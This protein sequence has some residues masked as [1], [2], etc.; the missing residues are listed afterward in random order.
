MNTKFI[1]VS[2]GVISGLG[3]G[4]CAASLGLLLQSRGYTVNPLKCENY[5]NQDSGTINPIDH[6]DPFLCEDGLEADMDLGVYERLLDKNMGKNNFVTKG[7][8]FKRILE[9]ERSMSYNGET[10]EDIPHVL[11]EIVERIKE[12]GRGYDFCII[13]IGGTAGEYQNVLYYEASR[14]M[15]TKNPKDVLNVHVSYMP[16]PKHLGEPK[17]KPT[18]MTVRILMSM[19]I[20]PDFLILRSEA[21]LDT[22]RRKL[23]GVKTSIKGEDII[24]AKDLDNIYRLPLEF[25]N[26]DFD[27]KVLKEF[28][29]PKKKQ[30]LN[31]WKKL[32]ESIEKPRKRKIAV[33]IA[34]KY[35][36]K[37]E[38]D[39]EL[40]DAYHALI[41]ALKHASWETNIDIDLHLVNVTKK[42]FEKK[43]KDLD[44][45]IVP[46]GWGKRGVEGKIKSITFARENKVPY[47]GLCY[48]MQLA[49]V[50]YARN[51]VGLKNANTEEVNPKAEHKIIHSIPFNKKYQVIKGDGVSMRLGAYDCVLKK[52]TL[53]YKIYEKGNQFKDKSK[54]I[55]SERHRHRFEF[56]NEYREIL[57]KQGLIFSGTSP[58]DFFVEFIELPKKIHPFFIATQGHPEYKSRPGKAHPLFKAL[59]KAGLKHKRKK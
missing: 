41:E 18:Q 4:L 14:Y 52:G 36:S 45:I 24:V 8:I 54:D 56:N 25:S 22:R 10:V 15:K 19:G 29:L 1:F 44:T 17:T 42:G 55:V 7:Q 2:G 28:N 23:L 37:N 46:I 33:G 32:I 58:D 53:A 38:G 9:K 20:H 39:Y 48:G 26:Q 6:G 31:K 3:K 49:C 59:L 51:V 35:L 16:I 21:N 30:N 34:G 57:E 13:E 40:T 11:N 5:L 43:L 12:S 50:E 27:A 47:L